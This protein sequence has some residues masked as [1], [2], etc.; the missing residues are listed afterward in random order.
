MRYHFIG[1]IYIL[2]IEKNIE[3]N[4]RLLIKLCSC[5]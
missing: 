2:H 5:Y 4:F 3:F 1:Y